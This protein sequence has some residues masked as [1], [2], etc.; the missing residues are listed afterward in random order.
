M[1]RPAQSQTG[2]QAEELAA[3][4][5]ERIVHGRDGTHTGH[6]LDVPVERQS[7]AEVHDLPDTQGAQFALEA[8]RKATR[9][10]Q[11]RL[12]L[13]PHAHLLVVVERV[14]DLDDVD[15]DVT[16]LTEAVYSS[17]RLVEG[18]R[19]ARNLKNDRRMTLMVK[20]NSIASDLECC[21]EDVVGRVRGIPVLSYLATLFNGVRCTHGEH[22]EPGSLTP[23]CDF[24]VQVISIEV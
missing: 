13:D 21:Y 1:V 7:E 4:L 16:S 10:R 23:I 2:K 11:K 18:W 12:V 22:A 20:I 24:P 5:N 15:V 14:V 17:E 8:G 6:C 19:I 3:S 9:R